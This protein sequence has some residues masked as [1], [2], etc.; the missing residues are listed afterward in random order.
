LLSAVTTVAARGKRFFS[1]E[2]NRLEAKRW[3]AHI[4]QQILTQFIEMSLAGVGEIPEAETWLA[5][6]YE[7]WINRFPLMGG[8]DGG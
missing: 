3:S 7:L 5:Y 2:V 8:D 4:W 1:A 6:A